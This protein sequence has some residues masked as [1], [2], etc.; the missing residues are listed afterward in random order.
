MI[1]AVMCNNTNTTDCVDTLQGVGYSLLFIV[2]FLVHA[3]ALKAFISKRNSWTDTHIYV[4]NLFLADSTLILFLPFRI[5]DAFWCIDVVPG[6]F[7]CTFLFNTHYINMYASIF[8]TVAL[9]VHRYLAVRFPMRIRSW[10]K[11]KE[12]A[13]VVCLFIWGA[14]LTICGNFSEENYPDKLWTCYERRKDIPLKL[15]FVL[16]LVI[17]GFLLPLLIVVFCSSQVI[18]ILFKVSDKTEERKGIIG[19][20]TANLVVFV[21]C[22][23]PISIG[24][25]VNYLN[26]VP[27]DWKCITIPAHTYLMVSEWIASTNCCFDAISYYFLLKH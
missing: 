16:L 19:I 25:T 12:T 23:T 1:I 27:A 5:Y 22:Y 14:I 18:Y 11:K 6:N 2:G 17:L 21:V 20:V 13:V 7:L 26:K 10:R 8:T 3:A 24:Y 15:D 9:S 4:F